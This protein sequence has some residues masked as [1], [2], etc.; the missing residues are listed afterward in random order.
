[1]SQLKKICITTAKLDLEAAKDAAGAPS[2]VLRCLGKQE[3]SW[4]LAKKYNTTIAMIQA[5]NQLEDGEI[6][7]DKL[8]LI[9]RKR[10]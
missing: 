9:P 4:E 7:H 2:L 3:S 5:A 1:M 8:L 6:P 10:A